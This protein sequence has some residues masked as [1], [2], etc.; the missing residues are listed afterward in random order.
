MWGEKGLEK[1]RFFEFYLL[2]LLRNGG[3]GL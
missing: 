3:V 2:I 1:L